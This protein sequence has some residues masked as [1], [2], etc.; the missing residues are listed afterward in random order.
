MARIGNVAILLS[1]CGHIDGSEI[2]ESVLTMLALSKKQINFQCLAPN[3]RQSV[4]V[5]HTT[6]KVLVDVTRNVLEESCRISRMG[7]CLDLANANAKHYD[8]LI[9]P[10]G[11]GVVKNLCSFA[12]DSFNAEIEPEIM[13]FVSSFFEDSKPVGAICIAPLLVAIILKKIHKYASITMGN[14]L[15]MA[16]AVSHF[17]SIHKA[18]NSSRDIIID[19]Q[20]KLVTTPGYMINGASIDDLYVGIEQCVLE[21]VKRI[22]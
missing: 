3:I 10:G 21:V 5:D 8:A 11:A 13:E 1:G 18:V 15:D 4:V 7:Q 19:E 6:G 9:I 2:H 17:G 20:L 22:A 16:N 12:T 14:S